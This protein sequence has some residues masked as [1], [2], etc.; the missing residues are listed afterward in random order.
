MTLLSVGMAVALLVALV[1][2]F[3]YY[4]LYI[5]E[6]TSQVRRYRFVL[7]LLPPEHTDSLPFYKSYMAGTEW[8]DTEGDTFD[9]R[10][11]QQAEEQEQEL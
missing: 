3:R 11:A 6:Y 8:A 1:A 7:K 9:F 10:K 2:Y 5:V 4:Q